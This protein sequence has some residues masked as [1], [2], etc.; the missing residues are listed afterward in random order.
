MWEAAAGPAEPRWQSCVRRRSAKDRSL[1][2]A[3][4]RDSLYV[5]SVLLA[6]A[7]KRIQLP[8]PSADCASGDTTPEQLSAELGV[9]DRQRT[10][11]ALAVWRQRCAGLKDDPSASRP[12]RKPLARTRAEVAQLRHEASVFAAGTP[13]HSATTG[14]LEWLET[15]EKAETDLL[16][17]M[18]R[19]L[20]LY[21]M[22]G[23]TELM[24]EP[25]IED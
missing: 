15:Y 12:S 8:A 19:R 24:P 9:T 22:L 11:A 16:A 18:K 13:Q 1:A 20:R 21:R 23:M 7:Q 4:G 10:N 2:G 25:L 3:W 5:P 6:W 17:R 14:R